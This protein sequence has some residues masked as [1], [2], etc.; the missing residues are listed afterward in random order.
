MEIQHYIRGGQARIEGLLQSL[1]KTNQSTL[2]SAM[3]YAVLSGGK[4]LRPLLAFASAEAVGGS[5]ESANIPACAVELVHAY[6]LIHDDLP[7]M[8]DDALRRGLPTC[9]IAY[10]EATAILAGDALQ[11]LAFELL[12]ESELLSVGNGTRLKMI[13][14]LSKAIG[15][16]GMVAGQ[17]ID[18]N[19][20]GSNMNELQLAQMH[21]LKTGA[22]ISASVQLGALSSNIASSQNLQDLKT[23]SACIGLAFQVKDDILDVESDTQTLGKQ[24]G[25]DASLN[26]PTYPSMLGLEGA[27]NKTH[28]LLDEGVA[29]LD[30][31]GAKA[32]SL[33]GIARYI[34]Q[35][36]Y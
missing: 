4:R 29:A 16:E 8:D 30:A 13:T 28:E 36:N 1:L 21:S 20:S 5:M 17:S 6:S 12:A 25:K 26:K 35:R 33:V 23:F 18:F 14:T 7:A 24:Q 2:Q 27:R 10:D 22:L 32:E 11:G 15:W 31:F 9:H 19:A 34:I 3:S